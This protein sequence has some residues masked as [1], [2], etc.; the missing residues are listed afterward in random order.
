MS[1]E[2]SRK[3]SEKRLNKAQLASCLNNGVWGSGASFCAKYV[4][5][6]STVG[7]EQAK[8]SVKSSEVQS[9]ICFRPATAL[10]GDNGRLAPHCLERIGEA[11]KLSQ[12]QLCLLQHV[13]ALQNSR[14]ELQASLF[15]EEYTQIKFV[16]WVPGACRARV[17]SSLAGTCME[18]TLELPVSHAFAATRVKSAALQEP[19]QLSDK[20]PKPTLASPTFLGRSGL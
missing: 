9:R 13:G 11:V 4:I 6:G 1:T 18:M 20:D 3:S 12:K 8:F 5:P 7:G 2:A 14:Y 19:R 15:P 17:Q 16:P 10:I